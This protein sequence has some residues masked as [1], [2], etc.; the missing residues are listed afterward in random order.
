MAATLD[1][2]L[3]VASVGT[4]DAFLMT[5]MQLLSLRALSIECLDDF[6]RLTVP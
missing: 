1:Q 5:A 2:D 3:T 6:I 4:A